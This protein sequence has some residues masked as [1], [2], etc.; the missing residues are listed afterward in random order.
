MIIRQFEERDL[1]QLIRINASYPRRQ[2]SKDLIRQFAAHSNGICLVAEEER[3]IRGFIL[4][5]VTP[6]GAKI[7][8]AQTDPDYLGEH[9]TYHLYESAYDQFRQ[10]NVSM[11]YK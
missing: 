11:V 5:S 6:P 3:T 1:S 8:D 10:A 7:L 4:I 2:V 9:I